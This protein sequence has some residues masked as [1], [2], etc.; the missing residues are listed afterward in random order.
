MTAETGRWQPID[1]APGDRDILIYVPQWGPLIARFN[2]EF[3][4]WSSRMQY[5]VSLAEESDRPTHWMPLPQPPE[6]EG[7]ADPPERDRLA[8]GTAKTGH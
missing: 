8:A 1:T 4:E 5:P 7:A 2:R 6:G 3:D